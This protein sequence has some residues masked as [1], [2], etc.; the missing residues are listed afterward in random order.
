MDLL[1]GLNPQQRAAVTAPTGPVLVLAG[2][3][4]GK[5]RVLTHRL[6]YLVR[7]LGAAP[8]SVV[9]LTF[10]NK[11]AREMGGRVQALLSQG[12]PTE[13]TTGRPSLGTFHAFAARLLRREAGRLPVSRE[14]VIFD[15]SDQQE[16]VRQALKE[17]NLDPKQVQPGAVHG[18]I[19]QAKNDRR[20]G[21]VSRHLL[22][23][24]HPAP[25]SATE[26]LRS[27]THWI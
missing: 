14:F 13:S 23:R 16:L 7:E 18:A 25:M 19:S 9:A 3:G 24:D 15:E 26:P 10:T 22:R 27:T 17:L 5:T 12:G 1:D 20:A 11:A 21:A 2:P 4:S 6:A 8:E